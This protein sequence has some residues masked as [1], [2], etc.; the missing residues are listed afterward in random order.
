MR[1]P[2]SAQ[3]RGVE[4]RQRVRPASPRRR[5]S[6]RTST[7]VR[8]ARTMVASLAVDVGQQVGLLHPAVGKRLGAIER[9]ASRWRSFPGSSRSAH[10]ARTRTD[11][12]GAKAPRAPMRAGPLGP[13]VVERH[14]RDHALAG[15]VVEVLD[16]DV[17]AP[18]MDERKRIGIEVRTGIGQHVARRCRRASRRPRDRHRR[19]SASTRANAAHGSTGDRAAGPPRAPAI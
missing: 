15:A 13:R 9:D 12:K 17:E 14:D 7:V 18:L 19:R 10:R 8:H 2:G 1:L 16:E 5:A 11:R 3:M 4:D 6:P